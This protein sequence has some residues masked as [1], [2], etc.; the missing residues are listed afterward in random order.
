[1]TAL[2][3]LKGGKLTAQQIAARCRRDIDDIYGEL[4][5]AESRGLVRIIVW[6]PKR[7][8]Q[9]RFWEAM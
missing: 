5:H 6:S 7:G 9:V 3:A 8:K 4:I 1:M 2:E